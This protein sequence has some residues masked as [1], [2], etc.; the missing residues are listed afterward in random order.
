[1]CNWKK[2][3]YK[4]D[5]IPVGCIPPACQPCGGRPRL[6]TMHTL[7]PA[8]HPLPSQAHPT[9]LPPAMHT[10]PQPHMRPIPSHAHTPPSPQPYM[11]PALPHMPPSPATHTPL[12]VMHPPSHAYWPPSCGQTDTCK[13]ITFS[14]L[15]F[16]GGKYR[17]L[18]HSLIS[19]HVPRK[20]PLLDFPFRKQNKILGLF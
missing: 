19:W 1:M 10:P 13:N 16:A 6:H 15:V 4:Q 18:K 9:F 5:S 17:F 20:N 8:I 3:Y 14:Q 7:S 12:P 11:I 2:Q